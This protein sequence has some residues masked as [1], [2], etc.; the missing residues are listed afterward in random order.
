MVYAVFLDEGGGGGGLQ[1]FGVA[2]EGAGDGHALAL[3]AG[4]ER[5]FCADER[6][7]AFWEGHLRVVS[8]GIG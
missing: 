1:D 5:A 4:E 7:E 6:G 3:P 8:I 2:Q